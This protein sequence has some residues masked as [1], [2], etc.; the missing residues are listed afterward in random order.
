[1]T[2]KWCE[3]VDGKQVVWDL[4]ERIDE[5]YNDTSIVYYLADLTLDELREFRDYIIWNEAFFDRILLR[6][7][8]EDIMKEWKQEFE[9][10]KQIFTLEESRYPID[11]GDY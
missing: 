3:W 4:R 6:S 2:T 5:L 9:K 7:D 1:M 8:V 11:T 10:C